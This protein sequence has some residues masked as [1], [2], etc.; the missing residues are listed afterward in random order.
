M[1]T[2]ETFFKIYWKIQSVIAPTLKHSQYIY[3][4]VLKSNCNPNFIWLDLGCGHQLLPPW[5][6][7]EETILAKTCK[8]VVGIDYDFDSLK[9]HRN[10]LYRIRGDASCLPFAD[11]SFDLVTSNMVF[12]HLDNPEVQLAE[13]NRIMKPGGLLIFHTPN[14]FSYATAMSRLIP[15]RI[16]DKLVYL[17]QGRKEEDVFPAYYKIN[18]KSKITKLARKTGFYVRKIRMIVSSAQFVIIPPVV[19][20][21]LIWIRMLMTKPLRMLRTNIIAIL[22]K[23]VANHSLCKDKS[24]TLELGEIP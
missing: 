17:L 21:E 24:E 20:F 23:A 11:N 18:S 9:K 13:I 8:T 5:R 16:K 19:I 6:S 4:L 15:E 7:Q 3:E 22:E 12:E 1:I 10:I 2:R 14:V